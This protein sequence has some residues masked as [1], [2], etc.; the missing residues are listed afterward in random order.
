MLGG[1]SEI[2]TNKSNK[3]IRQCLFFDDQPTEEQTL[4]NWTLWRSIYT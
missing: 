1:L 2:S 4:V 3:S